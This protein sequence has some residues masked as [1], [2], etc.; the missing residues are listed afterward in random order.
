M[1]T[2]RELAGTHRELPAKEAVT[3]RDLRQSRSLTFIVG[4]ALI[5]L[6]AATILHFTKN[7]DVRGWLVEV[8]ILSVIFAVSV[9]R[10]RAA[11]AIAALA[12][13]L[14]CLLTILTTST[15]IAGDSPSPTLFRSILPAL[16]ALFL[17]TFAATK[18]GG[19]RKQATGLAEPKH[20]RQASQI[21]ANLGVA[22]LLATSLTHTWV[23]GFL[24]LF[25]R[26]SLAND[27]LLVMVLAALCEATADTVSSE[28][29]Q[30]FAGEP[31]LITT[32]KRVPRGT[33]GAITRLGTAAGCAASVVV[34]LCGLSMWQ[35]SAL[36]LRAAMF[37]ALGGGIGL[38]FDSL[39][40]A[41][42]ERRG[43][44]NNDLVNFASTAFAAASA[45][46]LFLA[47][48]R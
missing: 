12:G 6:S 42:V 36:Q 33:D 43:W 30:A 14:I 4:L 25:H 13:G 27:A 16:L 47:C 45:L 20:G 48:N 32:L 28:I 3:R 34:A 1:R 46:A 19:L 15:V 24:S 38:F 10:L 40:G 7:E 23:E 29:G 5:V 37:A 2:D 18:A 9:W 22:G 21:I 35:G 26:A 31:I 44:I 41:T 39:L 17:L 11:T 8:L